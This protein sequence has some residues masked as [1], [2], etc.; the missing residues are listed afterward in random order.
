MARD[1]KKVTAGKL[2]FEDDYRRKQ[3]S[4][5]PSSVSVE[6]IAEHLDAPPSGTSLEEMLPRRRH[7]D[8]PP[9]EMEPPMFL[10]PL[11]QMKDI[12][13][14]IKSRMSRRTQE[15][16]EGADLEDL[17]SMMHRLFDDEALI[18]KS[19]ARHRRDILDVIGKDG[20]LLTGFTDPRLTELWRLFLEGWDI[21]VPEGKESGVDLFWEGEAEDDDGRVIEILQSLQFRDGEVTLFTRVGKIEDKITFD[22]T[23]FYRL[24]TE[25]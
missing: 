20:P 22:G 18:R 1:E 16:L 19:E 10:R 2:A 21:W 3:H 14:R 24:K 13:M 11:E 15:L 12:Y 25:L 17:I 23:A 7:P 4:G 9:V 5:D 8:L 6:E